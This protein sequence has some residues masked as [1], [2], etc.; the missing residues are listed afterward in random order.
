MALGRQ[1]KDGFDLMLRKIGG[2]VSIHKNYGRAN[3]STT[4]GR[5]LKSHE[6]N[7][8]SNVM[9]QFPERIDI[10]PGDVLQQKG[11]ADLWRVTEVEDTLQGDVYIHFEAK[12]EKIGA[13]QRGARTGNVIVQG[14]NYGGIQLNAAHGVQNIS[15]QVLAI[16][17]PISK[18]R[19]LL[20]HDEIDELDR[21]EADNALDRIAQL[22]QKEQT[23]NVLARIKEKLDVINGTFKVAQNLA[24]S[25]A[26]YIDA[27]GKAIGLS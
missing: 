26:P 27:I 12:V 6:K 4:E 3:Q 21:E 17:E 10:K 7:R 8:P 18:L 20:N 22:A 24:T 16:S 11:A 19:E 23:P 13:V 1:F 14:A 5:G 2:T 9:F 25:A 15:S